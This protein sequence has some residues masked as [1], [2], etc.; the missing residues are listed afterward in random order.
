[1]L[2]AL[3]ALKVVGVFRRGPWWLKFAI[4][5]SGEMVLRKCF[6]LL[7]GELHHPG[8][9]SKDS[10]PHSL[11]IVSEAAFTMSFSMF[12]SRPQPS[13]A[14]KIAAAEAEIEM[15]NGMVNRYNLPPP[16]I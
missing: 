5:V 2:R 15:I 12:G 11:H 9:T 7:Q 16:S 13:S 14:E 3:R 10:N 8:D 1:M 6:H 4:C